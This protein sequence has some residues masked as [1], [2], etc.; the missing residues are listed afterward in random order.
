MVK[1]T[2]TPIQRRGQM[3]VVATEVQKGRE[4]A[5]RA[6]ISAPAGAARMERVT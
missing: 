5:A 6:K 3:T 1:C 2:S 4:E